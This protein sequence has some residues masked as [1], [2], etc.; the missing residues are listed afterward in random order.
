MYAISPIKNSVTLNELSEIKVLEPLAE[1]T[2]MNGHYRA[3]SAHAARQT[4]A[5]LT[6]VRTTKAKVKNFEAQNVP[7]ELF[8]QAPPML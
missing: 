6:A 4:M 2:L 1:A 8:V 7:E 3:G 5:L